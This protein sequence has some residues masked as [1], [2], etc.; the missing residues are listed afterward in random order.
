MFQLKTY[1]IDPETQ[2][3]RREGNFHV[4]KHIYASWN[5]NSI[6]E[7]QRSWSKF[8][9]SWQH[10]RGLGW[11]RY[12][13][14]ETSMH[15]LTVQG[16]EMSSARW[17]CPSSCC[18]RCSWDSHGRLCERQAVMWGQDVFLATSEKFKSHLPQP[19]E[20]PGYR[21]WLLPWWWTSIVNASFWW[22]GSTNK[23]CGNDS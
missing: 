20:L 12:N 14:T 1:V 4:W 19:K 2:L 3:C 17:C 10:I 6:S 13:Q 18:V 11:L 5:Q 22:M 15:S 16:F 23:L 21:W 9:G 8:L 7:V